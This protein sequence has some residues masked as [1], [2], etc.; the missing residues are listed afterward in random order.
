MKKLA[1]LFSIILFV[2]LTSCSSVEGDAE[3]AASLNKESIDCIRNQDLQKAEELYKQSQEIIAQYKGT[4]KYEEFHTAYNKFM[5]P[6][7]KK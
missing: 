7:I 1:L 2:C 6:E 4:E 5:L 3:K